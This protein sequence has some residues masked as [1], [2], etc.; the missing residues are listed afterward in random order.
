MD[1]RNRSNRSWHFSSA[2]LSVLDLLL[3]L[4]SHD[5]L[6]ALHGDLCTL[7]LP[8]VFLKCEFSC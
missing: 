5:L 2:I 6:L 1:S 8:Q 3:H 4:T 7:R